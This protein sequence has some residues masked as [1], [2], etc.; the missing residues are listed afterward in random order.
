MCI[1]LFWAR[2][3]LIHVIHN[4]DF[5]IDLNMNI[6]CPRKETNSIVFLP[7]F[8]IYSNYWSS[9]LHRLSVAIDDLHNLNSHQLWSFVIR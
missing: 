2:D 7:V 8:H 5:S 6:E 9:S 3:F 4:R 1:K